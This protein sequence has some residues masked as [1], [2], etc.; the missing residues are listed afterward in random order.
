MVCPSYSPWY[1]TIVFMRK[2][3]ECLQFCIDF[4]QLNA[5][6]KKDLYP[7]PQIQEVIESLIGVGHYSCLGLKLG[8]WQV[9]MDE[10][11]K[12]NMAFTIGNLRFSQCEQMP[13]SLSITP[14]TFQ[15]LMQ[16]CLDELNFTYCLISLN[17]RI[18]Y[19]K[20]EEEHLHQLCVVFD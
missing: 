13:F 16:N 4:C 10:E 9:L 2:R 6:M 15:H 14:A 1:N 19:S 8:F 5:H 17:D 3:D 18:V 20:T 11:S 12:Q 7:L